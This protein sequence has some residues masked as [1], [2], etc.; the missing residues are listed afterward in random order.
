M[1]TTVSLDADVAAAVEAYC[2]LTGVDLDAAVNDLI[3][4]GLAVPHQRS[5]FRP[6]SANLGLRIDVSKVSE[7]VDLLDNLPQR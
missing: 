4:R 3:R 6:R 5:A 7:A 2:R 1:S